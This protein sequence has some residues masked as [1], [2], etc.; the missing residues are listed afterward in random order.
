MI[1][2]TVLSTLGLFADSSPVIIGAM[3]L[4]PII[5]PIVSFS[6]GMVRY[7]TSMIKTGFFTIGIGTL[8]ALFFSAGVSMI[9]PL[10]VV[11]SEIENRL[12]PTL[13]DMGI[14]IISGIAGAYGH[15]K[16][17]IA[18]SL[19]G[20]AIAVALVPPLAVA[21]IGIGWMDWGIFRGAFL[22]YLTNLSGIIMFSGITFLFLGYAPFKTARAGLF[23]TLIILVLIMVPLSLSFNQMQEKIRITQQLEGTSF[24]SVKLKNV[25]VRFGKEV[26]ISAKLVGPESVGTE[27]MEKIKEMI[28]T[29]I[30]Q[31]IILEVTSAIEF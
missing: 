31:P 8:V 1:L 26:L 12:S 9:I 10:D 25:K 24:R 14:A 5:E 20:V 23:Y 29:E 15:A 28:E 30:G 7:D 3:I 18:K 17:G 4:A 11:T 19:A 21:G 2:S 13:L 27:E 22:L 16:E 6:M